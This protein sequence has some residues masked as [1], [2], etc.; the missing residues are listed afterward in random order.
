MAA[1]GGIDAFL[2]FMGGT[3]GRKSAPEIR[4]ETQDDSETHGDWPPSLQIQGYDL[5][6]EM[7]AESTEETTTKMGDSTAHNPEFQ[8]AT[9]TK[10]IDK[11]SPLLLQA[12]YMAAQY[13]EV[14]ISQRKAGG[15]KGKSGVYFWYVKLEKVS[16]KNL[17]W[18][19]SESGYPTETITLEYDKITAYYFPQKPSGEVDPNPIQT[20]ESLDQRAPSKTKKGGKAELTTSQSADIVEQVI[21]KLRA[22]HLIK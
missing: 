14:W 13:D 3:A 9:V 22:Q 15:A 20:D 11:A 19:A 16:I 5:S 1:E 6:F 8:P 10:L 12:M 7:T 17:K 18:S 4:G 2:T 21:K